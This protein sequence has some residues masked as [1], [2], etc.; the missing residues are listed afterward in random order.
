VIGFIVGLKV[1][2]ILGILSAPQSGR[3]MRET[4]SERAA[5]LRERAEEATG[6]V[7][8]EVMEARQ[9]QDLAALSR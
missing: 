2:W 3:E 8:S 9:R 6:R 4:I 1:G 7:R 5:E